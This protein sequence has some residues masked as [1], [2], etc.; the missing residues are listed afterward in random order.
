MG[1]N[2]GGLKG[3]ESVCVGIEH[4]EVNVRLALGLAIGIQAVR[5]VVARARAADVIGFDRALLGRNGLAA[6][7]IDSLDVLRVAL[8]DHERLPGCEVGDHV[9]RC[10]AFGGDR[11]GGDDDVAA[12]ALQRRND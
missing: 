4:L 9:D 2:G 5:G 1:R 12:S 10:L 6:E 3:C 8:E 11:L 7:V